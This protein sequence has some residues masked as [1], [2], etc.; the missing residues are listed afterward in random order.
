[1]RKRIDRRPEAI[2]FD[3][4]GVIL[5]SA[6]VKTMAFASCYEGEDECDIKC[7]IDYQERHGGIGRRQKFEYFEEHV[8]GRSVDARRIDDLCDRFASIIDNAMIEA[9]FVKGAKEL[10]EHLHGRVSLHLVSGM[11]E[12]DLK[13][14]LEHR[15]LAQYFASVAGS[16]K[17]KID[18]FCRILESEGC[19]SAEVLAVGDSR[20]EFEAAVKLGIPFVAVVAPDA[21]DFFPPETVRCRD[22]TEFVTLVPLA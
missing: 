15:G 20:T 22:L 8:F 21:P 3:F 16:P 9:P 7:V 18:E 14:V 10:L 6:R 2:I 17:T 11:P 12:L 4:D 13:L 5:D 1:M 19:T